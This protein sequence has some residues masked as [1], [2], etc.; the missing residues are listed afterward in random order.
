M[1]RRGPLQSTD[2]YGTRKTER[3]AERRAEKRASEVHKA[4]EVTRG[5]DVVRPEPDPTWGEAA[6]M[7]YVIAMDDEAVCRWGS[8][9]FAALHLACM[10][11]D[12]TFGGTGRI[13]ADA[14]RAVMET[15]TALSLLDTAK[16][17]IDWIVDRS[18]GPD[19]NPWAA[20]IAALGTAREKQAP[21]GDVS[22]T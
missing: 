16:R 19:D 15:L 20:D 2:G 11:V 17:R 12:R 13:S 8:G 1:G 18:G 6:R 21:T 22:A 3:Q 14:Y 7:L 4:G 9:D 5:G 10:F